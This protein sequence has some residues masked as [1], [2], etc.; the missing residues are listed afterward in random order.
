MENLLKKDKWQDRTKTTQIQASFFLV[1]GTVRV[2]NSLDVCQT[3]Q[4]K[5]AD[6]SVEGFA[7]DSN[8]RD[9]MTNC[10]LV[11]H[12]SGHYYYYYY[13]YSSCK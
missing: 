5:V 1:F 13:Y 10:G 4:I 8:L 9:G 12:V 7:G 3:F 6:G 11:D 2:M